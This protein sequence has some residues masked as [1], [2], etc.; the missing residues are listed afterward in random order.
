MAR[1]DW[2]TLGL[3]PSIWLACLGP[4]AWLVQHAVSGNLGVDP[5]KTIQ[6]TTGLS[7]LVILLCA[8]GVTPLRRLP[9]L[10]PLIRVRRLVGLFAA[11]YALL[12]FLSYVIFD[13]EFSAAN[14]AKDVVKHPWVL[15]GF[16]AFLILLLL[17]ATSPLAMV[18][19]LG[20]KRWQA[21]HRLVYG[22]AVLGVL[23]FLWLVK[24]D[25]REPLTYG[26]ILLGLFA[27]RLIP[28]LRRARRPQ[29]VLTESRASAR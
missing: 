20:G 9:G 10:N 23:H 26:A 29:R 6:H 14:I 7:A 25:T 17:A 15:V 27:A 3:K 16:S 12:H 5:V 18:R 13:Q 11:F 4:A 1:R 8:L 19:R 24:K 21:I 2:I 28:R 22:A